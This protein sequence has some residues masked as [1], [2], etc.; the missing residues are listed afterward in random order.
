MKKS[1]K[2]TLFAVLSILIIFITIACIKIYKSSKKIDANSNI[3]K[4][5]SQEADEEIDEYKH[6][7]V[8]DGSEEQDKTELKNLI[9]ISECSE[10][11]MENYFEDMQE[12]QKIDN[13]ENIIIVI[14]K[15]DIENTYGATKV[16]KAPNNQYLLQYKNEEQRKNAL[17][18]LENSD[19]IISVEEN[20]K[21]SSLE[22]KNLNATNFVNLQGNNTNYNSWGIRRTGINIA[23]EK[24]DTEGANNNITVAIIDSGCDIDLVNSNYS[25]KIENAYDVFNGSDLLSNM[26]DNTGHGTHIAGTIAEGTPNSVKILPIKAADKHGESYNSDI[27][28]AINYIVK[29]NRANVINMSFGGNANETDR[30]SLEQAILSAYNKNIICVAAVGNDNKLADKN[31]P[32]AYNETIAIASFDKKLNKSDFSNYGNTVTFSA[33]GS[34]ISS[35]NGIKS[36]TSMATPHAVCAAAILKSYN[37]D[38]S[39]EEIVEILKY[40][41]IDLGAE[42]WDQYYGYGAINL[43]MN[44]CNCNCAKCHF[45]YCDE[46]E[47]NNCNFNENNKIE[48]V[49]LINMI[50]YG[51]R[52][53]IDENNLN[54]IVKYTN[55]IKKCIN[56]KNAENDFE[57]TEYNCNNNR[58]YGK[59]NYCNKEYTYDI[60]LTYLYNTWEYEKLKDNTI[61]LTKFNKANVNTL[62]VPETLDGYEVTEVGENLFRY[63]N[64]NSDKIIY[65]YAVIGITK[66]VLPDSITQIGQAAFFRSDIEEL[67]ANNIVIDNSAFERCENL[68]SIKCNKIISI[69]EYAFSSCDKLEEVILPEGLKKLGKNAFIWCDNLKK[70]IL[71]R[72]LQET[73]LSMGTDAR[74]AFYKAPNVIIYVYKDTYAHNYVK[75]SSNRFKLLDGHAFVKINLSQTEYEAFEKLN[76]DN[77]SIEVADSEEDYNKGIKETSTSYFDISYPNGNT[78][79]RY[80]DQY[81]IITTTKGEVLQGKAY[82][83]VK[84]AKLELSGNSIYTREAKTGEKLG[85]I[86]LPDDYEWVDKNTVLTDVGEFAYKAKCIKYD[87]D[88][89]EPPENFDIKVRVVLGKEILKPNII[90]TEKTYDGTDQIPIENISITGLDKINYE[91]ISAKTSDS[92]I[93]EKIA[94]IKIKMADEEFENFTFDNGEKEKEF[95]VETTIKKADSKI[96]YEASSMIHKYDGQ[97]YGIEL[98]VKKPSNAIIKY[99][100]DNDEYI[101]NEM[102][103]YKEIGTYT[104][105]YRIYINNNYTDVYGENKLTIVQDYILGDLNGDGK[106]N[107]KDWNIMY[108]HINETIPLTEEQ[109]EYAD[110]NNDGKVNIKDWNRMYGHITEVDPLW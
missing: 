102:P 46:C 94:K 87:T 69:G 27:I 64:G 67:K 107:I 35:V 47:C 85:N 56:T 39:M 106:V 80:G 34:E 79:F 83:T 51:S 53:D 101:L 72:S 68:T 66:Y 99:A 18:K 36:G 105:K 103:K 20:T 76:T 7:S 1:K 9:N 17:E 78:S 8:E 93:G 21:Y 98:K 73:H 104:I 77:L 19:G 16:V 25:G 15:K 54:L 33:P 22:N 43:D 74:D 110:L 86:D 6:Q 55:G 75:N 81:C 49:E 108:S 28:L 84:K 40:Y 62:Y 96:E 70:V 109:L 11:F 61:K 45:M 65:N 71:P 37:K 82:V 91:I 32:S 23:K 95:E 97:L 26:T 63:A 3:A 30:K 24:I 100:N 89:Y 31:Y 14:S 88:N 29:E 44:Y 59:F 48:N 92:N 50:D 90:I 12:L 4:T 57:I 41:A 13:K 2:V 42:G 52:S 38:F 10:E 58:F 60:E 5:E